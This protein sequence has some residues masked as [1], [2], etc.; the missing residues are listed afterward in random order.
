MQN[1]RIIT[2]NPLFAA[3]N[4]VGLAIGLAVCLLILLFVRDELSFDDFW[5]KA[6]RTYRLHTLFAFPN[7]EPLA[8]VRTMGPLKA[9]LEKDLPEL[10]SVT[11]LSAQ[12]PTVRLG[13]RVFVDDIGFVDP[14]FIEMTGLQPLA[15]SIDR[16]LGDS[17][18]F[19]ITKS[20]AEKYFG[21][22]DPLG[23]VATFTVFNTKLEYRIV[24]VIP[25]LPGNT[26]LKFSGLAFIDEQKFNHRRVLFD[27]WTAGSMFTYARL[28]PGADA[29]QVEA[30]LAKVLDDNV[31]PLA[32]GHDVGKPSG[33]LKLSMMPV[34]DIQLHARG[35]GEMKPGGDIN[36]VR[37]FVAIALLI[38]AI[39][40]FN[41]MN[42]ATAKSTERAQEVALRKLLGARRSS[43]VFR[44]LGESLFMAS[45]GL[46]LAL[47]LAAAALP[48]YSD[49]TGKAVGAE[50]ALDPAN[51]LAIIGLTVG[52]GVAGGLYP[53]FFQSRFR[54]AE[55]LKA[56]GSGGDTA[57]SLAVRQGLVMLQF[58]ISSALFVAIAIVYGQLRYIDNADLGF[59]NKNMLLV[60]RLARPEAFDLQALFK[61]KVAALPGVVSLARSDTWP[62]DDADGVTEVGL[63][64]RSGGS[65]VLISQRTVDEDFLT[66]YGI[67]LVA[68]RDFDKGRPADYLPLNPGRVAPQLRV[69][70]VIVNQAALGHLGLGAADEAIGK[71][72]ILNPRA[73]LTLTVIGVAAN[74]HFDSLKSVLKP[75]IYLANRA[76]FRVIGI[77]HHRDADAVA[78]AVE[79]E[80]IWRSL[81]PGVPFLYQNLDDV[82]ARQYETERVQATLLTGFAGLAILV[83]CLGLY[84]VSV[85]SAQKRIREIAVRK[86][87]G[88]SVL[89]ILWILLWQT[90]R[91]VLLASLIAGPVAVYFMRGWL[92]QYR[93]H[94]DFA[95]FGT[96][97]CLA[98]VFLALALSWLT[99]GAH[100]ASAARSR[101]INALRHE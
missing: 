86:I 99:V 92:S 49:F 1:L 73:P 63:P 10:E 2:R 80:R 42:L 82:L 14:G 3:I 46:V 78:L 52:V 95:T 79:I 9:A 69:A 40:C 71:N 97:I 77:R 85:F 15:G 66:T 48:W 26:H 38:L 33:L 20:L 36:I 83:A 98:A 44:F 55:T 43:L 50:V 27:S 21:T 11:R 13:E 101:P 35:T 8:T 23:Q 17:S 28:K 87:L 68:G 60:H 81:I 75:E 93:Y 61:R 41:F 67:K 5:P 45:L 31:P 84:G 29:K 54:P 70:G 19:I 72:F 90:T 24:A 51:W 94:F 96:V 65:T 100:A 47:L 34:G 91:T 53:A 18:A 76:G 12:R 6:E 89:Q 62:G 25:D 64:G 58:A 16:H 39:A 30:R 32:L 56:S 7:L 37:T 57:G 59:E 22:E 88:A 4:I 74:V